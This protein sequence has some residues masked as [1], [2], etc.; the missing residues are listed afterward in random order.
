MFD[1]FIR[2]A[3]ARKA[4]R[5]GCFEDALALAADPAIQADRRAEDI[6]GAAAAQLLARAQK[7]LAAKDLVAARAEVA[8]LRAAAPSAAADALAGDVQAAATAEDAAVDL[9]RRTLAEARKALDHGETAAAA[10]L[11]AT[12]SPSH[13]LLERDQVQNLLVERRRAAAEA[14][15]RAEKALSG[16]NLAAAEEGLARAESLDR[17][18]EGIRMLRQRVV[19]AAAQGLQARIAD[20]VGVDVVRALGI[21]EEALRQLPALARADAASEVRRSLCAE[22]RRRLAA[23]QSVAQALPFASAFHG[24]ELV[25]DEDLAALCAAL[26]FAVARSGRGDNGVAA[27]RLRAAAAA[28]GASALVEAADALASQ[29]TEN[30]QRLARVHGMVEA[31]DLDAARAVLAEILAAEPLHEAAR[32]DL[33]LVE[34]GLAELDRRLD[35]ARSSARA[36]RLREACSAALALSGSPRVAPQA[37]QLLAD[38]RARMAVVDRGIDE[39]RVALHGRLAAG[40]EGVR[41]CLRRL[42][43]LAKVQMDHDELPRMIEAVSAEIRALA[44]CEDVAKAIDREAMDEIVAAADE[45]LASCERLIARHRLDA[46]LAD[47]GDRLLAAA[48]AA[49]EAGRL[50]S[51]DRCA[52]VIDR[53]GT[54]LEGAATRAS[55]LRASAMERRARAEEQIA[56]AREAMERRDLMVAERAA[57]DAMALWCDGPSVR[58]TAAQ[59]VDVRRQADALGRVEALAKERDFFGANQRLAA[60][61][62][63]HALLRTRVHDMKKDLARAQGLEG[64]FLLRVDEGG[65]HLVLRGETV[66]FGNVQKVR[67]DVPILANLA[68]LHATIRRSMSFHG[69]MQDT[70]VAEEGEV[71]VLGKRVDRHV[72][73]SGDRIQLGSALGMSFV[74]SNS[75]SLSASLTLLG[76]FQVAGTDRLLLM[77]DRGRDGR[78]LLGSSADAHVRVAGASGEVEL[79][80]TNTGQMRVACAGGGT[81]DGLPF[82]GE[83]P[84]AAGQVVVASGVTF[85]LL[86]WRAA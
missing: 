21:Y 3:K 64:A 35:A 59:I 15:K 4:L 55:S 80:A 11:L 62:P 6:R 31:G 1:R 69:G 5:D 13:L 30:D 85:V 49:L 2:L 61:P 14:Q 27:T 22:L 24:S 86:P 23:A 65:E 58:Q 75:R 39:V 10:A 70:V 28:I 40:V 73:Q 52:D 18:G 25:G 72:L 79:F 41:H 48:G 50:S 83:Q 9:A 76:G 56:V 29:A 26:T 71:R 57:A 53:L 17:D 66:S 51:V 63:T 34:Q 38:V 47:L 19:A 7:H 74:R 36:G 37:A 8:R 43:E 16:G 81:V 54:A 33:E 60:M 12:V 77:K 82:R 42:E 78:I 67:A 44:L 20:V 46:R 32:R 84:V 68:G 45:L